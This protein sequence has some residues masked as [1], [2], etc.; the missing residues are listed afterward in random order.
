MTY[1][2]H[3]KTISDN[4]EKKWSLVIAI[5]YPSSVEKF[6][7]ETLLK[8]MHVV[9]QSTHYTVFKKFLSD[10]FAWSKTVLIRK[11]VGGALLGCFLMP[12]LDTLNIIYMYGVRNLEMAIRFSL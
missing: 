7:M 1:L 3:L 11:T 8:L 10:A 6:G 2:S 5:F 4:K 9:V 12:A